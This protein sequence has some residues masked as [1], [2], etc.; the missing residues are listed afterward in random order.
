MMWCLMLRPVFQK[1]IDGWSGQSFDITLFSLRRRLKRPK[2]QNVCNSI[3][4]TAAIVGLFHTE[5]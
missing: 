5:F 3:M 1:N 4:N 2:K